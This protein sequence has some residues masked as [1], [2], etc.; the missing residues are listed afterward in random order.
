MTV[1]NTFYSA[2]LGRSALLSDSSHTYPAMSGT[3]KYGLFPDCGVGDVH[4]FE[5]RVYYT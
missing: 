5:N 3:V 2:L 4:T 1:I